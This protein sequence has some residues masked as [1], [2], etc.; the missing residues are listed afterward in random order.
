VNPFRRSSL[1]SSQIFQAEPEHCLDDIK[2]LKTNIELKDM[3]T[4]DLETD[5]ETSDSVSFQPDPRLSGDDIEI[6]ETSTELKDM[7]KKS[8]ICYSDATTATACTAPAGPDMKIQIVNTFSCGRMDEKSSTEGRH[9]CSICYKSFSRTSGLKLHLAMH[10][11]V[12]PYSCEICI[13]TSK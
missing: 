4:S 10:N 11:G 5:V 2:I 7:E 3:D 12:R 1:E 6:L 13:K 9:T 8:N